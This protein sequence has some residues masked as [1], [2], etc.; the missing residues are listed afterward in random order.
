MLS[1]T[2]TK[3]RPKRN[4]TGA[5]LDQAVMEMPPPKPTIAQTTRTGTSRAMFA[6]LRRAQRNTSSKARHN[7]KAKWNQRK[8]KYNNP[9]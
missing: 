2:R 4:T 5:A 8:T 6:A 1:N 9:N 7:Q 3:K